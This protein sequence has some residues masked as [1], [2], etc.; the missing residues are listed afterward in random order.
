MV[1]VSTLVST[2]VMPQKL[3]RSI[4]SRYEVGASSHVT[5]LP[6]FPRSEVWPI[7]TTLGGCFWSPVSL[8]GNMFVVRFA[9]IVCLDEWQR[10]CSPVYPSNRGCVLGSYGKS[11][12]YT[13]TCY[14]RVVAI[15]CSHK[16]SLFWHCR[17][18]YI[19]LRVD[20]VSGW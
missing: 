9:S 1:Q 7:S 11:A 15:R 2:F 3:K 18:S 8:L 19:D 13:K 6:M 16:D 14:F 20:L 12:Q 17:L 4:L 10:T 5:M